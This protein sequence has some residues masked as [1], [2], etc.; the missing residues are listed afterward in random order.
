MEQLPLFFCSIAFLDSHAAVDNGSV[1]VVTI[2][3][4]KKLIQAR[5][6]REVWEVWHNDLAD[7]V[8]RHANLNRRIDF[9][10]PWQRQYLM[11]N[12]FQTLH[13]QICALH[14]AVASTSLADVWCLQNLRR[15][16]QTFDKVFQ[17]T[18]WKGKLPLQF[19][20]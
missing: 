14:V 20:K 17:V 5:S 19:T 12:S 2:P 4:R 6:R 9:W 3:A 8:A 10:L 11:T 15:P 13:Q 7:N 1:E 16:S 18:D